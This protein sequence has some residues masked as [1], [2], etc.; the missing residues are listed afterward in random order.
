MCRA[1]VEDDYDIALGSQ[2]GPNSKMPRIRRLGNRIFAAMLGIL[3][4]RQVVDPASGIR[5]VNRS[6]LG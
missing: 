6:S 1:I 3:C 5:V 4:G 2:L